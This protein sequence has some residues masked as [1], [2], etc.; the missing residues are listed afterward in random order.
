[1]AKAPAEALAPKTVAIANVSLD[2]FIFC[3]W[4]LSK[5]FWQEYE[6]KMTA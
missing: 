6:T 2:I 4:L 3:S 5:K 1:M